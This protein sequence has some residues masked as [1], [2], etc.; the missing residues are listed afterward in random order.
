M[1]FFFY[2]QG[3]IIWGK[4][5]DMHNMYNRSEPPDGWGEGESVQKGS[6]SVPGP[7]VG[8]GFQLHGHEDQLR[9]VIGRVG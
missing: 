4:K 9:P 1:D 5:G 7:L 2:D 8:E 6:F 3:K